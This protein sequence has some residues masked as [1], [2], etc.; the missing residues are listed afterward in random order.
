MPSA[1][2]QRQL[3]MNERHVAA[4]TRAI[5]DPGHA[6]FPDR[7]AATDEDY[8]ATVETLIGSAPPGGLWV[9]AYGSLIWNP[10]FDFEEQRVAHVHGWRRAFCLGWDY[11]FRGNR[12]QPGL[13]LA[14]DRG[15]SCRGIAYRLGPETLSANL[16]KLVRR[17]M[18]MV[19][20]AFPPRWIKVATADGPLTALTFAIDRNSG[21]YV[22][23]LGDEALADVLAS[24]CGFRG[25]MAEYL[26]ATVSHLEALGIHDRH[27]WRMQELVAERIERAHGISA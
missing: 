12:D 11:R 5:A 9:F 6:V 10:A 16:H 8:A 25:S 15:G 21:R 20:T 7:R 2:S 24:A 3:R 1:R 13:M 26:L 23:G 17:E 27:L 18:S 14:L 4:V 19:P 22:N